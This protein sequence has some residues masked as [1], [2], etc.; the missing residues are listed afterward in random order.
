M[1]SPSAVPL[2]FKEAPLAQV[3]L[4]SQRQAA[5]GESQVLGPAGLLLS[6]L[7][8]A[9]KTEMRPK[10]RDESWESCQF[11]KVALH[12]TTFDYSSQL[13]TRESL[14]KRHFLTLGFMQMLKKC[15]FTAQ[16]PPHL[17]WLDAVSIRILCVRLSRAMPMPSPL[18]SPPYTLEWGVER[19]LDCGEVRADRDWLEPGMLELVGVRE[20]WRT[21]W[22]T[23]LTVS[24]TRFRWLLHKK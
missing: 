10:T 4:S 12:I 16:A 9:A 21:V 3:V 8:A 19:P 17:S 18:L 24:N 22:L 13:N 7:R 15:L 1:S 23:F 20:R 6:A 14:F 5:Q 11:V 2:L